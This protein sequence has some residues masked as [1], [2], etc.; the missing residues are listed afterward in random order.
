MKNTMK[1][2]ALLLVL[3]MLAGCGASSM[4]NEMAMEMPMA[5]PSS[6]VTMTLFFAQVSWPLNSRS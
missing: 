1:L 5:K 3:T 2:I 4:K 6:S